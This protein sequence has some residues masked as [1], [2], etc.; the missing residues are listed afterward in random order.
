[1]KSQQTH[2]TRHQG[3]QKLNEN[4]PTHIKNIANTRRSISK[5]L[6][7]QIKTRQNYVE[8]TPHIKNTPKHIENTTGTHRNTLKH[9][10]IHWNTSQ[11]KDINQKW[12]RI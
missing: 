7:I 1:M 4:T 9:I 11:Y 2:K 6:R 3:F 5:T 8:N 12:K 10:S